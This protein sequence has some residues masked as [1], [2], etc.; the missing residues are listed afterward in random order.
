MSELEKLKIEN[1]RYLEA[2]HQYAKPDNWNTS[3]GGSAHVHLDEWM[4]NTNDRYFGP[5]IAR[6]AL[7][8]SKLEYDPQ[9]DEDDQYV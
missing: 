8:L 5:D 2:L 6:E 1:A 3:S 9:G 7:G 4:D